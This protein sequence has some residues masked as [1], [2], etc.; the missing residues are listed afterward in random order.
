[1]HPAIEAA[2]GVERRANRSGAEMPLEQSASGRADVSKA[3]ILT[4]PCNEDRQES[5]AK[6]GAQNL[7]SEA[8]ANAI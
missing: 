3:D 2:G 5:R 8:L 4:S 6:V 7:Y 1:M